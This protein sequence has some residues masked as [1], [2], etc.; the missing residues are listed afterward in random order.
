MARGRLEPLVNDIHP[1]ASLLRSISKC[2]LQSE[3]NLKEINLSGIKLRSA[4]IKALGN[5]YI[6]TYIILFY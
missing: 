4:S 5:V 2:A 1:Q 6:Y 3:N